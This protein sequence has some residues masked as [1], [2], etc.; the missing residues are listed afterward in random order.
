M[1]ASGPTSRCALALYTMALGLLSVIFREFSRMGRLGHGEL[2]PDIIVTVAASPRARS[3]TGHHGDV[4]VIMRQCSAIQWS[5]ALR[6]NAVAT[7]SRRLARA[8]NRSRRCMYTPAISDCSSCIPREGHLPDLSY[9]PPAEDR[10]RAR[11][12]H[13]RSRPDGTDPILVEGPRA[14]TSFPRCKSLDSES[15]HRQPGKARS[16]QPNSNDVLRK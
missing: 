4:S 14:T 16:T 2:K 9:A 5:P 7:M 11:L 8:V 13:R 6:R 3:A 12:A 10:A 15:V 1:K